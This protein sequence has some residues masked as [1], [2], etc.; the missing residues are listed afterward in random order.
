MSIL[1]LSFENKNQ[2]RKYPLKQSA[3][4]VSSEGY[5]VPDDLIVNASITS[6]FG[7]HCV[8]IKQIF[9]SEKTLKL[10]ITSLLDDTTLGVFSGDITSD[11]TTLELTP[12][13]RFVAGKITIGSATSIASL[14]RIL[15]FEPAALEFEES[16]VFCYAPPK[17][18]SIRDSKDNELRGE[19]NYGI[20]TGLTKTS[21]T[22]NKV[23]RLRASIPASVFNLADKS[24]LLE[25]C[26]TP[27]IKNINGVLPS[28]ISEDPNINPHHEN[29][30]NIY[31]AGIRPVIFYKTQGNQMNWR[32]VWKDVFYAVNDAVTYDRIPYICTLATTAGDNHNPSNKTYWKPVSGAGTVAIATEGVTIDGLCAQK[33][34]LLPP[35]DISGF[36]LNLPEFKDKYYSKPALP[37]YDPYKAQNPDPLNPN[38]PIA[39]PAR[40]AG[41][42]YGSEVPE[43]YFWPQF[44]KEEYYQNIK[45]WS[46]PQ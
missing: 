25:N 8:Y 17:V 18:T 42:F 12:F 34:K 41:S 4:L 35:V 6:V 32:G 24:S 23:T 10:T 31:I 29:D 37:A 11:Y 22:V 36:S 15:N 21:D 19:V 46:K 9:K 20:L 28:S 44:A 5:V 40:L 45:Y 27:S 2:F 39:R 16:V 3:S 1:A 13:E 7:K 30:G 43:Y 38:Y 33:S 26:R 14:P